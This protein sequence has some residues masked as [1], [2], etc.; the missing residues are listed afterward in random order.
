[1]KRCTPKSVAK[2]IW[3]SFNYRYYVLSKNTSEKLLHLL[4][5]EHIVVRKYAI[6]QENLK[7]Y[8][9]RTIGSTEVTG[10]HIECIHT[11]TLDSAP[12]MGGNYIKNKS[13]ST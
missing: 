13:N 3:N 9:L 10:H 11:I 4:A 7:S 1:M 8:D 5:L 6:S 2:C 12:N